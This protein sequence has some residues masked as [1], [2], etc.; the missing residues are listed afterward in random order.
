MGGLLSLPRIGQN[1]T[2]AT[3]SVPRRRAL[4]ALCQR[5]DVIIVEDD[6]YWFLQFPSARAA[7]R[8]RGE[9]IPDETLAGVVGRQASSG[10]EFLDS[11]IP[12]YLSLDVDGRVVRLD[13]FS[14]IIAP[15]CRLGWMTAQRAVIDSIHSMTEL[16]T[17]QPSGFTQ[18][19]VA[20]M[21]IGPDE[22]DSGGR[23]GE[24][25][26]KGWSMDGWVR[27]LEG[28]RGVYER[29]MQTM[30]QI[31][32]DGKH[33]APLA[34]AVEGAAAR[35][36]GPTK[37]RSDVNPVKMYDFHWPQGGMF[38][39]IQVNL[40]SH[41]L[42]PE[43]PLAKL[44]HA[45]WMHLTTKPYLVLLTPGVIFSATAEIAEHQGPKYF[46]LCFAAVDE[47]EDVAVVT[48]RVVAGFNDFWSKGRVGNVDRFKSEMREECRVI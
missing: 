48:H 33:L 38:V 28:L 1:P 41:P 24:L 10:Y 9:K 13:S 19:L 44:S 36:D 3:L 30:C 11:L 26:G 2:G 4:Y 8:D 45:L 17:Q 22:V 21:I 34:G 27:W 43:V 35:G 46:R 16:N 25:N 7:E 23:G 32:D 18:S 42:A 31:L 5:Y 29:R 37:G 6:P 12:S 20:Q 15:G 47:R 14:K 39:W 40:S